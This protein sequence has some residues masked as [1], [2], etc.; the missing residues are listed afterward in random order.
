MSLGKFKLDQSQVLHSSCPYV[1]VLVPGAGETQSLHRAWFTIPRTPLGSLPP[2]DF[3]VRL[4]LDPT[5]TAH[6]SRFAVLM[7]LLSRKFR[8]FQCAW[9]LAFGFDHA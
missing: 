4:C 3:F 1:D 2:K 8:G 5:R 7:Y 6:V 9:K